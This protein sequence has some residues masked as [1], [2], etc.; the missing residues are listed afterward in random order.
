MHKLKM[1]VLFGGCS[2]EHDVSIRSAQ[3]I[4]R[5]L[6]PDKFDPLYIGITKTGEWKLCDYPEANWESG[7]CLPAILSP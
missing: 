3:E 6:D 4:A 7:N 5:N 2:E 1:A